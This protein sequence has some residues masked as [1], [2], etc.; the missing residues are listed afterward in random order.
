MENASR[1]LVMAGGMLIA[2]MIVGALVL[3]FANLSNYQN[4]RGNQELQSQI[5]DFNNQFMP[6]DKQNLTLMELKSLYNMI[7]NNN[8]ENENMEITTNITAVYPD[9]TKNFKEIEEDEKIIRVFKCTNVGYNKEGRINEMSFE[10]V[11]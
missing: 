2:L 8:K 4:Q 9:I 5:V 6:Y 10:K 3:L 1:A 7:Q 11:K